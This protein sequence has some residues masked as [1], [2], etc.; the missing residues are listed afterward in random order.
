MPVIGGS[1]PTATVTVPV[2]TPAPMKKPQ[3]APTP[4]QPV[5]ANPQ[6]EQQAVPQGMVPPV[7]Q[8]PEPHAIV[9]PWAPPPSGRSVMR[10]MRLRYAKQSPWYS[11]ALKVIEEKVPNRA[12][13]DQIRRTLLNNGVKPDEM[14]WGGIDSFLGWNPFTISTETQG[15]ANFINKAELLDHVKKSIL[16]FTE[17][18]YGT[19]KPRPESEQDAASLAE[20][21]ARQNLADASRKLLSVQDQKA[22]IRRKIDQATP[23]SEPFHQ[24]RLVGNNGF[25]N[26]PATRFDVV[27]YVPREVRGRLVWTK[28]RV[29]ASGTPRELRN[30]GYEDQ[31]Y[32]GVHNQILTSDDLQDKLEYEEAQQQANDPEVR[33]QLEQ[34][35]QE[36]AKLDEEHRQVLVEH[37]AA[38]K[39]MDAATKKRIGAAKP[40]GL[41][42]R[43]GPDSEYQ[44]ILTIPGGT[45][46]RET[47][48]HLPGSHVRGQEIGRAEDGGGVGREFKSGHFPGKNILYHVRYNDFTTPDGRK[49]LHLDEIQS[50]LAH[51]FGYDHPYKKNWHEL[52]LRKMLHHAAANGYDGISWTPG[53]MQADR[54]NLGKVVDELHWH[55]VHGLRGV[56]EGKTVFNKSANEVS[57]DNLHTFVGR[58][59]AEALINSRRSKLESNPNGET[60]GEI[61]LN[62]PV[63]LG[64]EH[65][66]RL[67]DQMIP[68]YLS[69]IGKKYGAEIKTESVSNGVKDYN[70][71]EFGGKQEIHSMTIPPKLRQAVIGEGQALYSRLQKARL[72]FARSTPEDLKALEEH[73]R[74]NPDDEALRHAWADGLEESGDKDRA[75][76]IRNGPRSIHVEGRR[77]FNRGSGNT[78]H[79]AAITVDGKPVEGVPRSY[80]YGDM[81]LQNAADKLERLGIVR[82][83][84]GDEV[85]RSLWRWAQAHGVKF[86]YDVTDVPR[87]RDLHQFSRPKKYAADDELDFGMD[88]MYGDDLPK[89]PLQRPA[90]KEDVT[91]RTRKQIL[92]QMLEAAKKGHFDPSGMMPRDYIKEIETPPDVPQGGGDVWMSDP[93]D[94]LP[95]PPKQYNR[96]VVYTPIP[97]NRHDFDSLC[98]RDGWRMFFPSRPSTGPVLSRRSSA[99]GN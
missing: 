21:R 15:P 74:A 76:V 1:N 9:L 12:S 77:W 85:H 13:A 22:L 33:N 14:K 24:I 44:G 96:R 30:R 31:S 67:Y 71:P 46:Y 54:Y 56:K 57:H 79:S 88:A 37:Q 51:G 60:W 95:E 45:N 3:P 6:S 73:V 32:G 70:N 55:P 29:L 10:K 49:L 7:P 59:N 92:Q 23:R 47:T 43:Y 53:R 34:Y 39:A 38:K 35:R 27:R 61:N 17:K 4:V 25:R 8:Q 75:N 5:P 20:D 36:M 68:N 41:R 86:T 80:G 11:H 94:E 28:D 83:K 69:K 58:Q 93:E 2:P 50:D 72:R 81:Y 42:T 89:E 66:K 48:V 18:T 99:T 62:D 65:H 97:R 26:R 84:V 78:Y 16:K 63:H 91:G 40:K 98:L 87:K 19:T 52:A 64:G 90:P 82:S